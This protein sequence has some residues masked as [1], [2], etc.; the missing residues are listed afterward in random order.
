MRETHQQWNAKSICKAIIASKTK[1]TTT[2]QMTNFKNAHALT[3]SK[4]KSML[5]VNCNL[6][7][8]TMTNC[9]QVPTTLTFLN[10]MISIMIQLQYC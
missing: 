10:S 6:I 3:L 4:S 7:K 5:K 9:L 1:M 2:K 8:K